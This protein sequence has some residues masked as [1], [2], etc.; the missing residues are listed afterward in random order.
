MSTVLATSV[1]HPVVMEQLASVTSFRVATDASPQTLVAEGLDAAVIIVRD[2]LPV[3]IFAAASSLRGVVR[4]G[5]GL[6]M[7]PIEAA[8]EAGVLVANVPGVNA[9]SVAEYV[10]MSA[11]MLRRGFR[12]VD[13]ALRTDGWHSGRARGLEGRELTGATIGLIGT[14]S[15]GQAVR[16]IVAPAFRTRL[17]GYNRSGD[18]PAGIEY[19]PLDQLLSESDV[20]VLACPLTEETRGLMNAERLGEMKAGSVLINVARG[21]VVDDDALLDALRAGHLRG[22]ALD[23]FSQ[24][25]L[26]SNHPLFD[27]H[28]VILTPHIAGATDDSMLAIGRGAADA[29]LQILDGEVPETLVNPQVLTHSKQHPPQ[30]TTN[31]I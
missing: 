17:L 22:A 7:V 20:L 25:P 18:A 27:M 6:D 3:D 8:T 10:V 24:Q 14:G 21:P 23:V 31:G 15:V 9:R 4:H 12:S 28:N 2:P 5:V 29:T 19:R 16:D 1:L 11:L 13:T 30:K 26:A